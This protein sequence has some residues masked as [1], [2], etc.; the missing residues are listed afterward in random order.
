MQQPRPSERGSCLDQRSRAS[1]RATVCGFSRNFP[2]ALSMTRSLCFAVPALLSFATLSIL[3]SQI[4][5]FLID[6]LPARTS[7]IARHFLNIV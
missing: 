5:I 2:A 7:P 1:N 6:G 4:A 3:T